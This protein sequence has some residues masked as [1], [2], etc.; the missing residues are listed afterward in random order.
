MGC[1]HVLPWSLPPSCLKN[2]TLEFRLLS[3]ARHLSSKTFVHRG[4]IRS[5]PAIHTSPLLLQC[6]PSLLHIQSSQSLKKY[7]SYDY[8]IWCVNTIC[9]YILLISRQNLRPSFQLCI[10]VALLHVKMLKCSHPCF[11]IISMLACLLPQSTIYCS[12]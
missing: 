4:D 7:I 1:S 11:V 3:S 5:P 6:L 9:C 12:S 10:T 8:N 2:S